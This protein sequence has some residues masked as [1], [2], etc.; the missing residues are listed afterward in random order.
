MVVQ[1]AQHRAGMTVI[2]WARLLRCT[3]CGT[4]MPILSSPA[5][6]ADP[7]KRHREDAE[8]RGSGSTHMG[9]QDADATRKSVMHPLPRALPICLYIRNHGRPAALFFPLSPEII[10]AS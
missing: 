7:Q 3:E 8:F 5:S 1:V 9:P 6:N 4:A 2:D 10:G